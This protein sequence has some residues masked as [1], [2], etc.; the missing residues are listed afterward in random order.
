MILN[1]ISF[2]SVHEFFSKSHFTPWTQTVCISCISK[3]ATY[4]DEEI[5]YVHRIFHVAMT[6][7]LQQ[8]A[9]D[10]VSEI[11]QFISKYHK[12]NKINQLYQ[13]D[14]FTAAFNWSE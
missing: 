8:Y 3:E 2:S 12:G 13:H 10:Y 1:D 9:H 4:S 11:Q 14:A 7:S 6:F 5:E